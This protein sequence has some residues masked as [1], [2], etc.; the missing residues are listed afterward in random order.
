[1]PR[2][3]PAVPQICWALVGKLRTTFPRLQ[4]PSCP[5]VF[6]LA[7]LSDKETFSPRQWASHCGAWKSCPHS[8]LA[9]TFL[10]PNQSLRVES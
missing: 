4:F 9:R 7:E 8:F 1:M 5:K 6:Y 10:S 2:Q 3:G